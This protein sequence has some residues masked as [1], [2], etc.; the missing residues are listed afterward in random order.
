MP[1]ECYGKPTVYSFEGHEVYGVEDA[2]QYLKHLYGDWRKLPPEDKR[3]TAHNME[4]V[5][6]NTPY[7]DYKM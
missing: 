5:D 1:G 6:L 3:K 7:A 2:D 4:T